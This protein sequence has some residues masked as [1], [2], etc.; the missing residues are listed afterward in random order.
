METATGPGL[1]A[2]ADE[3]RRQSSRSNRTETASRSCR[4]AA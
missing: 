4:C 1:R 3:I 2:S